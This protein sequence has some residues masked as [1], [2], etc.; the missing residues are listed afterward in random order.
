[1]LVAAVAGL[2]LASHARGGEPSDLDEPGDD[3]PAIWQGENT[4]TCAWPSAVAVQGGGLCTGTLIHPEVVVYAAHCGAFPQAIR[5]GENTNAPTAVAP[6]FCRTNPNYGGVSDQGNDWAFCKLPAPMEVP[7]TPTVYGCE[8]QILFPGQDIALIG[9]GGNQTNDSGAGIKRWGMTTLDAINIAGNVSVTNGGNSPSVCPGDSGGPAM[10]RFPD[11]GWRAFGIAS[12]VSGGCSGSGTHSLIMGAAEWI[13]TESG[14]D[15]TVCHDLDGTWD[16]GPLCG[17]FYAQEPGAAVSTWSESCKGEPTI[18]WA[19]TCGEALPSLDG[20]PPTVSITSPSNGTVFDT[21]PA[22]FDILVDA[23]DDLSYIKVSLKVNGE[24]VAGG[25]DTTP[26]YGFDG[27][28]F[29]AGQWVLAAVAEDA[30]GNVVESAPVG[31]GVGMPAPDPGGDGDGDGDGDGGSGD[32]DGSGG[33]GDDAGSAGDEGGTGS[34]GAADDDGSGCAVVSGATDDHRHL[35]WAMMVL[36]GLG[37]G[38]SR[39]RRRV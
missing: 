29:P 39:R 13:E 26:P 7:F 12:T 5:F 25:D 6:E 34:F 10:V 35:G 19:E 38:R 15:I 23:Q 4:T 32:D 33:S 8:S 14:V 3:R 18:G 36:L 27:V 9:F 1:V 20:A 21:A 30:A 11:G 17:G 37:L 2:T 16:P 31:I 24:L 28:S 22:Q